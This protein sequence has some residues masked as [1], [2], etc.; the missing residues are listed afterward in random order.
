M[1]RLFSTLIICAVVA[2]PNCVHAEEGELGNLFGMVVVIDPGHGGQDPGAIGTF[3]GPQKSRV[4][5]VENEHVY[6]VA[7]R[8]ARIVRVHGGAAVFTIRDSNQLQSALPPGT[9]IPE[10]RNEMYAHTTRMVRAKSA[11]LQ[12]RLNYA[13]NALRRYPKHRVVFISLHFDVVGAGLEGVRI[14]TPSGDPD[15]PFAEFLADHFRRGQRIRKNVKGEE[16]YPVAASGTRGIPNL[17]ILSSRNHIAQRVLIELGNF[18]NPD[19][20]WRL[21]DYRV[22][23]NYAQ[24]IVRALTDLNRLALALVR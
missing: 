2:L 17:Y 19:D 12:P 6:D 16:H 20:N 4:G 15:L 24:Y 5:V 18:N 3:P 14:I 7:I 11:G 9:P 10:D 23:E 21:R 1:F 8:L 22:R 13:N